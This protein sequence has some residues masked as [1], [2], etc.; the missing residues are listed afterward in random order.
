MLFL[1][2]PDKQREHKED[3]RAGPELDTQELPQV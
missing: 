2:S 3:P 1:R